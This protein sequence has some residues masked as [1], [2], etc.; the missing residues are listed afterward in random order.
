M[1]RL[2]LMVLFYSVTIL[3]AILIAFSLGT[4]AKKNASNFITATYTGPFPGKIA[5][6]TGTIDQ[7]EEEF[8]S[9]E[10]LVAKYGS[11]KI[12]HVTW[13]DNYMAERE[14]MVT[15]V[16]KLAVDREIKALI[17]N[18]AVPGTIAAVD[19]LKDIRKDVFIV[20]CSPLEHP[21]A[22]SRRSNLV[23]NTNEQDMAEPMVMQA[24]KQGA[25]TFV[26]YS[27]PRHMSIVMLASRR[28]NIRAACAK[29]GIL[30]VDAHIPDPG[31]DAGIDGAGEFILQDVSRM[32]TRYGANTAF[33]STSCAMQI[34]LINGVMNTKAIYPQPCNPSPFHGFPGAFG[35]ESIGLDINRM[36]DETRKVTTAN[37]MT[38]RFSNY[39][40]PLPMAFTHA[41]VEYAIRWINGQVPKTAI[42]DTAL[43]ECFSAYVREMTGEN[44]AAQ[45]VSYS[46]NGQS[47]NNFKSVL[48]D[49]LTY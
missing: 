1:K 41:G 47:L 10:Q 46:E 27:F 44:I 38:G 17:I 42:D 12:V 32:V 18:Q 30:F 8:F 25:K 39:P 2:A 24:K 34:P 6:V 14:Y 33:F 28:D 31:A 29:E 9:A 19:K 4:C 16:A 20:L 26:H 23:L 35:L 13:P 45:I 11:N 22:T 40:V 48:M 5:V 36:V 21:L 7:G 37:N 3:V 15:I 49:Y 43:L